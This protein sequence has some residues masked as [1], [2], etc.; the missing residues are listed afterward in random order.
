MLAGQSSACGEVERRVWTAFKWRRFNPCRSCGMGAEQDSIELCRGELTFGH[1]GPRF[2]VLYRDRLCYWPASRFQE[3][4][5]LP[6]GQIV[7]TEIEETFVFGESNFD[8]EVGGRF[9]SLTAHLNDHRRWVEAFEQALGRGTTAAAAASLREARRPQS[10]EDAGLT[11]ARPEGVQA[12][13]GSEEPRQE[14]LEGSEVAG[15]DGTIGASSAAAHGSLAGET[16]AQSLGFEAEDSG[17][18]ASSAAES[19]LTCRGPVADKRDVSPTEG[20]QEGNALEEEGIPHEGS[21]ADVLRLE[22]AGDEFELRALKHGGTAG[23]SLRPVSEGDGPKEQAVQQDGAAMDILRDASTGALL[24]VAEC[25]ADPL[26][27]PRCE[28]TGPRGA[29]AQIDSLS[30]PGMAQDLAIDGPENMT[31]A[32]ASPTVVIFSDDAASR[33][34]DSRDPA[35][36]VEAAVPGLVHGSWEDRDYVQ[37]AVE[38]DGL[39]LRHAATELQHDRMIVLAAVRQN[40]LALEHALGDLR[41]DHEIVRAACSQNSLAKQFAAERSGMITPGGRSDTSGLTQAAPSRL[42][43]GVLFPLLAFAPALAYLI[44][45][46]TLSLAFAVLDAYGRR[47]NPADFYVSMIQGSM[48]GLPLLQE[49]NSYCFSL[50][51]TGSRGHVELGSRGPPKAPELIGLTVVVLVMDW[52]SAAIL[53]ILWRLL[54]VEDGDSVV[55]TML[56]LGVVGLPLAWLVFLI[57][58]FTARSVASQIR[59][60]AR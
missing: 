24:A 15:H 35:D 21:A 40:G 53:F 57:L 52:V 34:H 46:G 22:S 3:T 36:D 39:S 20:Q 17:D 33:G 12:A 7:M 43:E 31:T 9:V 2:V 47:K 38:R 13:P 48:L 58:G 44:G 45:P 41:H 10:G 29:A 56:V 23:E 30:S 55:P 1:R 11:E 27:S 51:L 26:T 25:G 54:G 8:F 37:R 4:G 16:L 60:G 28:V 49:W 18:E 19:S 6:S 50:T 59:L 32:G 14:F 42:R 5:D